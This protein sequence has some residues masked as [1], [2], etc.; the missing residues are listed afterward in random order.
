LVCGNIAPVGYVIS[1]TS[2]N[3]DCDDSNPSINPGTAEIPCNGIDDNCDGDI[4]ENSENSVTVKYFRDSD[5]D[6]YGNLG[7]PP[8]FS[9]SGTPVGYVTDSTDCDDIDP[10][11]NPGMIEI[12]CNGKDDNCSGQTDENNTSTPVLYYRDLDND[13]YGDFNSTTISCNGVPSG[14]ATNN[15]DCDD[16]DSSVYRELVLFVDADGDGYFNSTEPIVFLCLGATI[17]PGYI[18]IESEDDIPDPLPLDCNDNNP[19]INPGATE[20]CGNSIDDNCNGK[21]MKVV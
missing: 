9:C 15:T 2:T 20:I 6:G 18:L 4:D 3:G 1:S 10:E 5:G 21:Q 8:V 19:T 14:Y 11:V 13:G 7:F 16:T 12:P 17:P